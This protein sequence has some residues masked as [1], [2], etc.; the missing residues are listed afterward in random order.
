MQQPVTVYDSRP[1]QLYTHTHTHTH[2]HHIL[3]ST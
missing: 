2:T 3:M 1:I